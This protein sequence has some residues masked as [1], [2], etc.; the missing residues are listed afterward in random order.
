MKDGRRVKEAWEFSE[1]REE[2]DDWVEC[3]IGIEVGEIFGKVEL[4]K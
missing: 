1:K 4:E 3:W 2:V